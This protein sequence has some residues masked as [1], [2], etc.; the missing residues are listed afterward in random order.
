LKAGNY[1]VVS[2][3]EDDEDGSKDIHTQFTVK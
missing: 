1:V 2:D 3:T